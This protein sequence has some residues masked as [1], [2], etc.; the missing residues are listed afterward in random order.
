MIFDFTWHPS[1]IQVHFIIFFF[2]HFG[3]LRRPLLLQVTL[4][5]TPTEGKNSSDPNQKSVSLK[6]AK[7]EHK[8]LL[9]YP[10][11]S[12]TISIYIYVCTYICILL[13]ELGIRISCVYI[14]V[15]IYSI[16]VYCT[17][18]LYTVVCSFTRNT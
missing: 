11:L 18:S 1:I 15:Y 14:N 16:Y 12:Y 17:Y 4:E 9:R 7:L 3:G 2:L 5:S 10:N 8:I 6:F 13:D